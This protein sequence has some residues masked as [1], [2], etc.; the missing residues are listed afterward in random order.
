[1]HM[2]K[3][4]FLTY[5]IP[6]AAPINTA[7]M[8]CTILLCRIPKQI[9]EITT[10]GT[11]PYHK[12]SWPVRIPRINNSSN[13]GITKQLH[14]TFINKSPSVSML[15]ALAKPADDSTKPL[16]VRATLSKTA[17][18]TVAT[19]HIA[20]TKTCFLFLIGSGISFGTFE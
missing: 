16:W 20:Y 10:A 19:T 14:N 3:R 18:A 4:L 15:L 2:D 6:R 1:M 12:H 9:E 8:N 13:I 7:Y 11:G 17:T 5:I